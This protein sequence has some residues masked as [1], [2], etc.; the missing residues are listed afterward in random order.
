MA[1]A[2]VTF[3]ARQ[4]KRQVRTAQGLT[5]APGAVPLLA[6]GGRIPV[7]GTIR[8]IGHRWHPV[9]TLPAAACARHMVIVGATGCGKTNLMIRLW[10]GWFTATLEAALA[11]RG[12]RPLL[13]VL[14]CKGGRD[15]RRKADRTRRL[16]YGAGARRVAIWPDEA[17]LSLWDL[18]PP[19]LAVL[20]YQMIETGTGAA[21]YY[22]DI[23]QAVLTLAVT[24]PG[25]PPLNAAAF[26]DRL[27][28]QLAAPAWDDG[29]HPAEAGP[30]PRRRPA[31]G[32][33]PAPLRHPAGRLGPA[34]DGPG[35]LAEAD[36]WYF[37]L[38]GTREPS[39]AEA[40]AMALTELA[41]HAATTRTA[42]RGP[43]CWPPMTT[44]P[45]PAACR[46][47]T[48]T[49]GAGPWASA[50]RSAPSPGRAWGAIEDER[51]R[52]AAT[53]DGG[54]FV[55]HTPL[56]R[57]AVEL[58]GTRRVLETAHKLIGHALGR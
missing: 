35:T 20:L 26:L 13:V 49:S 6:R 40:Q 2:P 43:S 33:H 36:A 57:A 45:C 50:C 58:A 44:P 31:P 24:A 37:I 19:D 16:L 54:I 25:G 14:D 34:L 23:L 47:R 17:R 4:W 12:N 32:R 56:P 48:C 42:S 52:I 15:A 9:F 10:A 3:D 1:S 8:A 11:G 38:E 21:A 30:G 5:E 7:G 18:P 39:V 51:Y 22:A 28:A 53:A 27:D 29:S 55:M 41:A 46:C